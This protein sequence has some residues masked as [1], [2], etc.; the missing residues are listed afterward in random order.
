VNRHIGRQNAD[1]QLDKLPSIELSA[2]EPKMDSENRESVA[3]TIAKSSFGGILMGLANLVPGIS[4]GTML[5]AAGI[6]PRFIN[7]IADVTTFRFRWRSLIVLASVGAAA[8]IGILLF[9]GLL[10]DL[11]INHRWVMYCLFIGLTLGGVPVVYKMAMPINRS[12]VTGVVFAFLV[13]LVFAV[14]QMTGVVGNSESNFAMLFVAGLGGAS[15]MILPGVSGG[16]ILLLLGQYVPILGAIDQFKDAVSQK[17][18]PAAM[19]PALSVMLPVGIGVIV[20]IVGVSNLLKWLLRKYRQATLGA[21]IGLLLGSVVGLWPFQQSVKPIVGQ[22]VI[23][24]Q[25]VTEKNID[26]FEP[27]DWP[28]QF[29]S[30]TFSQVAGA[31]G[32]ISLGM[33]TTLGVARIG[34]GA[35]NHWDHEKKD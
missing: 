23:K 8:A 5:L 15:A 7:A 28:T 17:D 34:G 27:E 2:A 20:G 6:Y 11:V 22:T 25:L 32:L 14:L 4:G 33:I 30:P 24:S 9:A 29:F 16:Y 19:E 3:A 12:V 21:L 26:S 18:F 31:F 13:M 10:K 35:N 1:F